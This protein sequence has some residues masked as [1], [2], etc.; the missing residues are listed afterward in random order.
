MIR[1]IIIDDEPSAVN[2]LSI[3]LKKKCKDDV[4]LIA[5]STSP[6]EGKALIEQHNPDLVLLLRADRR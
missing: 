3:L 1:T 2:V 4:E 6:F 5:T